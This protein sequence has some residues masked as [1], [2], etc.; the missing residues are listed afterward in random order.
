ME[1][2]DLIE[3]LAEE[4]AKRITQPPKDPNDISPYVL[5]AVEIVEITRRKRPAE[6]MLALEMMGIPAYR[7]ADNTIRVLKRDLAPPGIAATVVAAKR[8][9]KHW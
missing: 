6:Q 7:L 9:T 4:L 2:E 5:T 1:M 3:R 8:P